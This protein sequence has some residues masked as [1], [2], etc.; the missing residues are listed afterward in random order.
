MT[1]DLSSLDSYEITIDPQNKIKFHPLFN[2]PPDK[3]NLEYKES[4]MKKSKKRSKPLTFN[5]LSKK[6][7]KR[8]TLDF[9]QFHH[10]ESLD[11]SNALAGA[12][13]ELRNVIKKEK[14]DGK[15]H[16]IDIGKKLADII[17]YADLLA[18][19]LGINLDI[20]IRSKFN[21]VSDK[22]HSDIKL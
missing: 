11:W 22:I 4:I 15:N 5:K 19:D 14:R 12:V 8:N 7:H 3:K 2:F 20:A 6:N 17:L 9:P 18:S 16:S 13:G 10:W 21:E 1:V